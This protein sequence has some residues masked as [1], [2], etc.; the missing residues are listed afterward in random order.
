MG[1]SIFHMFLV[2]ILTSWSLLTF[3]SASLLKPRAQSAKDRILYS[4]SFPI[5]FTKVIILLHLILHYLVVL[6]LAAH[7]WMIDEIFLGAY[8]K[9]K[10]KRPLIII[11]LPRTGTTSLHEILAMDPNLVTPSTS[12]LILPFMC[13]NM[14]IKFC[15][16][17]F[18]NMLRNIEHVLKIMKGITK[19]MEMRHPTSLFSY[20]ADDILLGE[21]NWVSL[22]A[23]R[24]FPVEEYWWKNY[25]FT[26][27]SKDE[28]RKILTFHALVCKKT[29][30][31]NE[32]SRGSQATLLIRSHLSQCIEDF[33]ELYPDAVFAGII[34]DPIQVLRSFAGLYDSSVYSSTGVRMFPKA[35]YLDLQA[36]TCA[37]QTNFTQACEVKRES[38][39]DVIQRILLDMMK[40]EEKLFSTSPSGLQSYPITGYIKFEDFKRDLPATIEDLYEQIGFEMC[41]EFVFKLQHKTESH[42]EYKSNRSYMNPTLQQIGIPEKTFLNMPDVQKYSS[43]ISEHHEVRDV[44]LRRK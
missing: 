23:V 35:H 41:E 17:N 26:S 38:W 43:L 42:Y 11:S 5:S 20:D 2:W 31:M 37:Q 3:S 32:K 10:I 27:F 30:F 6:P 36:I 15:Y 12:E 22:H 13:A 40:R 4:F 24:T 16:E 18:P 7:L 1:Y 29:L 34:R 25:N 21:W 44:T 9:T 33:T 8:R 19:D 28:K 39:S 14:M